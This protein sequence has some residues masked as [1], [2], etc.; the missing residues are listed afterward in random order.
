VPDPVSPATAADAVGRRISLRHRVPDPAGGDRDRLTDVVGTLERAGDILS[1]R[2]RDGS[3]TEVPA[4]AVVAFR[5]VP[6]SAGRRGRTAAQWPPAELE[7][8]AALGWRA[9][10]E[11]WVGGARGGWLLRAAG[12]FTGRA[13][14]V[15]PVGSPPLPL[16]DA[17]AEVVAFYAERGLA[18]RFQLPTGTEALAGELDARGWTAYDPVL[19][20]AADLAALPRP[21]DAASRVRI[22]PAPDDAW[23]AAYHYRGGTLPEGARSVLTRGDALAFAS[24]RDVAGDVLAIARGSLDDSWLGVTAVEVAPGARRQGLGT[25]VVVALAAW[26]RERAGRWAYLQV[27]EENAA[28]RSAYG[29]AGFVEHHRYHYRRLDPR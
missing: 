20:L 21:G 19:V 28:A 17:L 2:R 14:S 15:L 12:G 6:P 16:D 5:V 11:R 23:I 10:E 29:R 18:P 24:V 22:D 4:A 7:Q 9:A 8:V 25:L 1:L 3:L 26:A 27:A 13:N